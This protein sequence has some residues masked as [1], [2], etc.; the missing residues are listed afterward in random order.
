VPTHSLLSFHR[1]VTSADFCTVAAQPVIA[2]D[3][4][5]AAPPLNFALGVA[6]LLAAFI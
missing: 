1:R 3:G 4:A 5:K 2:A 6:Q